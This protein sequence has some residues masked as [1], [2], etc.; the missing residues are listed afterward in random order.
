MEVNITREE[1]N[2][3][4]KDDFEKCS[5]IVENAIKGAG[6]TKKDITRILM[7]GGS[8]LIPKVKQI[9]DIYAGAEKICLDCNPN[10]AV[11]RGAAIK[12]KMKKDE[13]LNQEI[14]VRY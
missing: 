4:C 1:F 5:A 13:Y 9:I 7:V 3:L 11:A 2:D 12:A 10:F 14:C 8:S 6:L